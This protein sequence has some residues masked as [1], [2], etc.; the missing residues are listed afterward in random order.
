MDPSGAYGSQMLNKLSH[1]VSLTLGT[2]VVL[3]SNIEATAGAMAA[4]FLMLCGAITVYTRVQQA[5]TAIVMR[6]KAEH[7]L[8]MLQSSDVR[9]AAEVILNTATETARMLRVKG[10][11]GEALRVA[12]AKTEALSGS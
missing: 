12:V 8:N 6:H 7:E 1:D 11:E 9:R 10:E 5:R 2:F 3:S 4:V